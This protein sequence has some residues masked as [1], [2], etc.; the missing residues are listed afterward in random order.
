[1]YIDV[2]FSTYFSKSISWV[3]VGYFHYGLDRLVSVST[4][5]SCND[6]NSKLM[7]VNLDFKYFRFSYVDFSVVVTSWEA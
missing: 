7:Y 1:M 6:F 5:N 2:G 4:S 3:E